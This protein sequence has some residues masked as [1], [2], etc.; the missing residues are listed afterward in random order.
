MSSSP[1]FVAVFTDK[2]VTRMSVHSAPEKLDLER[3][4]KLARYAYESRTGKPPPAFRS[5]QFEDIDGGLLQAYSAEELNNDD[6]APEPQ[7]EPE[8]QPG[9]ERGRKRRSKTKHD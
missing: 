6:D 5:A 1:I 8:P 9:P 4:K 3:G 2:I 7:P